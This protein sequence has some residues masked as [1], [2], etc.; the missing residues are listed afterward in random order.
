MLF[1]SPPLLLLLLPP[2]PSSSASSPRRPT[3]FLS[4]SPAP[5]GFTRRAALSPR[6]SAQQHLLPFRRALGQAHAPTP[7]SPTRRLF[8]AI[9]CPMESASGMVG[10]SMNNMATHVGARASSRMAVPTDRVSQARTR[11]LNGGG[12]SVHHNGDSERASHTT[13]GWGGTI[14]NTNSIGAAFG[15][16]A[17]ENP[18]PRG[19]FTTSPRPPP[20]PSCSL[21]PTRPDL[22]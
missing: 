9:G 15:S 12:V 22:G 6:I 11:D 2:P 14:W 4:P 7:V 21:L 18:R 10:R 8:P 13:L 1:R 20:R 3:L 17:R 5:A 19:A 16:V